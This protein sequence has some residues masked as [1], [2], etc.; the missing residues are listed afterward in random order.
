[1][2]RST[3]LVYIVAMLLTEVFVQIL[4]VVK[5]QLG[6]I[7]GVTQGEVAYPLL[8]DVAVWGVMLV[9]VLQAQSHRPSSTIKLEYN[10]TNQVPTILRLHVHW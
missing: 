4:E 6:M 1:M 8:K 10:I 2:V 5:G 7:G 9:C 3:G